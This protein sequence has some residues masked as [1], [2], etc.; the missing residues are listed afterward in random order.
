VT[1]SAPFLVLEYEDRFL[2][3][4]C[5]EVVLHIS[6]ERRSMCEVVTEL[7]IGRFVN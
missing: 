1:A 4:F 5:F 7:D 2:H 6:T 3:A